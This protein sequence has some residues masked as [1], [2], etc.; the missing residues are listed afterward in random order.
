MPCSN[1][2]VIFSHLLTHYDGFM[3]NIVGKYKSVAGCSLV[4]PGLVIGIV[5]AQTAY[6]EREVLRGTAGGALKGAAVGELSGGDAGKGAAW[7]AAA[8]AAKGVANKKCAGQQ[9]VAAEEKAGQ[10]AKI[11]ELEL[12]QAY[13]KGRQESAGV[14][15]PGTSEK[16]AR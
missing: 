6:A 2:R 13:E 9:A 15:K 3:I 16:V 8:G 4:V 5:C 7:G 11:R 14:S 1:K 12:R 10:D